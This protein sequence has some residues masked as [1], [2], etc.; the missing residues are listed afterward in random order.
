MLGLLLNDCLSI[1]SKKLS[2][3]HSPILLF[4]KIKVHRHQL[5]YY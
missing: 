4:I 5:T 1:L 2:I 3:H